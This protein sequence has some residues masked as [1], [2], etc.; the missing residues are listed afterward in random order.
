[1][2][3]L[4]TNFLSGTLTGAINTSVQLT[5]SSFTVLPTISPGN[6][7]TLTLDPDAVN[8]EPEIIQVI[9]HSVSASSVFMTRGMEGTTARAH[10]VGT[11]WV[12]SVTVADYTRMGFGGLIIGT[13]GRFTTVTVEDTL[14]VGATTVQPGTIFAVEGPSHIN[15]LLTGDQA[16]FTGN[17]TVNSEVKTNSYRGLTASS[18]IDYGP[19]NG[20]NIHFFNG[21]MVMKVADATPNNGP[22]QIDFLRP[23]FNATNAVRFRFRQS[24]N[25]FTDAGGISVSGTTIGFR[26]HS[27]IRFKENITA[28]TG[29]T[30]ALEKVTVIK[31][32]RTGLTDVRAGFSAQNVETIPEFGAFVSHDPDDAEKRLSLIESEFTPF[33]VAAVQE[34][35]ARV[36][37]LEAPDA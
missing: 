24:N 11:R 1:M 18:S 21:R 9:L 25:R 7:L 13:S 33:L 35:S 22:L 2:T 3:S 8:G 12:N 28:L 17:L 16:L 32:N 31:Y 27:D 36:K 15:G 26:Q 20:T 30:T 23:E 6:T 34:L 10:P 4:L 37:V 5:D 29:A 19:V 14:R